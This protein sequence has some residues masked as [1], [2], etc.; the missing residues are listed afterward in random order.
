MS[1]STER[2]TSSVWN[3]ETRNVRFKRNVKVRI[4]V[5]F[6]YGCL[7]DASTQK[8]AIFGFTAVKNLESYLVRLCSGCI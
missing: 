6:E 4:E 8:T 7:Q 3:L 1:K 2:S 5:M